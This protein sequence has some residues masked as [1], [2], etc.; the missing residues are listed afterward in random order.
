[1]ESYIVAAWFRVKV[2][3]WEILLS[4]HKMTLEQQQQQKNQISAPPFLT[5]KNW[6]INIEELDFR[7]FFRERTAKEIT[8]RLVHST[9]LILPDD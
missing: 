9:L 4:P 3:A 5:A 8:T 6:G 1:M 2:E 7:V